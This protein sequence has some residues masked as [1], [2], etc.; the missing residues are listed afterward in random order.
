[1]LFY[2]PIIFLISGLNFALFVSEQVAFTVHNIKIGMRFKSSY[3][4]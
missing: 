4:P 1:M 3:K 2:K